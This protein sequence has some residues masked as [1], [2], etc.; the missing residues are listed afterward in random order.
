MQ[1]F[2]GPLL[3]L[4]VHMSDCALTTVTPASASAVMTVVGVRPVM[5]SLF[6]FG[7]KERIILPWFLTVDLCVGVGVDLELFQFDGQVDCRESVLVVAMVMVA[8]TIDGMQLCALRLCVEF[9]VRH[10]R[11]MCMCSQCR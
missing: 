1:G 9:G 6:S 3:K 8:V 5:A 7:R 10:F 2:V 4:W 11:G